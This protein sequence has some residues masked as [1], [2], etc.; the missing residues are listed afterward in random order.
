[1]VSTAYARWLFG[2]A[3]I[4]NITIGGGLLFLRPLLASA[5]HLSPIGG[6]NLPL[7]YLLGSMIILFGYAYILVAQDPV[8]Y[9]PYIHLAILG[10]LAAVAS[11][12]VPWL[13]GE[14]FWAV[15]ALTGVDLVYAALFFLF[16]RRMG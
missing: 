4:F 11:A 7:V 16:L 3:G 14:V 5:L 13:Q 15:P 8:R 1:M 2:T 9:R 12:V 6:A 10:K